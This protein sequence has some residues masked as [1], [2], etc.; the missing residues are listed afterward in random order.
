MVGVG[1]PQRQCAE[2]EH[3]AALLVASGRRMVVMMVV[4]S[5]GANGVDYL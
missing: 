5:R 3:R 2:V 4:A 1:R